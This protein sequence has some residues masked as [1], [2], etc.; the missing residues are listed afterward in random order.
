MIASVILTVTLPARL[1]DLIPESITPWIWLPML[2]F[3][4][5]CGSGFW[6]GEIPMDPRQRRFRRRSLWLVSGILLFGCS[7]KE[8]AASLAIPEDLNHLPPT[9]TLNQAAYD[10]WK[11]FRLLCDRCHGEDARGTTFG[12]DLLPALRP[13]GS[14]PSYQAFTVLML[15]GRPGKGMPSA[16][17][18]GLETSAIEGLYQYLQGRADGTYFGGRPALR[19]H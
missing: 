7:K 17:S 13:G 1:L 3:E 4:V 10:G 14:V 16:T 2:G 18:L 15:D 8:K 19:G 6:Y 12:P 11:Q 9:D 5:P